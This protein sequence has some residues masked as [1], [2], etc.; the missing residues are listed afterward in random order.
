MIF[1]T[2]TCINK[3]N[4]IMDWFLFEHWFDCFRLLGWPKRRPTGQLPVQIQTLFY[5]YIP[6]MSKRLIIFLSN[7]KPISMHGTWLF[8]YLLPGYMILRHQR[9]T[10]ISNGH[11]LMKYVNKLVCENTRQM[12]EILFLWTNKSFKM[13]MMNEMKRGDTK[14]KKNNKNQ[15]RKQK[16]ARKR[17]FWCSMYTRKAKVLSN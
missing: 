1:K 14:K 12:L 15:H 11:C 7:V 17:N 2:E 3:S 5:S 13:W 6:H 10:K 8:N 16:G 4:K 9:H